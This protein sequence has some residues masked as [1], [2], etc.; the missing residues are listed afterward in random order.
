MPYRKRTYRYSSRNKKDS[1][2]IKKDMKKTNLIIVLT[3]LFTMLSYAQNHTST[4]NQSEELGRV[5]WYRDYDKAIAVAKRENKAVVLLFQ[6][7]PGCATC[8]NY[9]H[10]V[11]SHPLIVEALENSFI[12]LAIHNN[13][14]GKDREILKRFEEPSWNNPVVRIIDVNGNDLVNRIGNDYSAITLCQSLIRTLKLR[15]TPIPNYLQLL[16]LELSSVKH[17]DVSE[18]Y[19]A[20]HCFWTGEKELGKL[21]GVI[22]VESG[23]I[24]HNEVVKVKYNLDLINTTELNNYATLSGFNK[25]ENQN[26]SKSKKDVHYFLKNTIY[27]YMPLTELQK[28]KI[29]SALG[30]Q[31]TG[32]E[33]LSPKQLI[34]LNAYQETKSYTVLLDKEFKVAWTIKEMEKN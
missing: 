3:C 18:E 8:R 22:D 1:R 14:A 25:I 30:H 5:D 34:W 10:N 2:R 33:Y 27:K 26:Y 9:G 15:N 6:E 24:N 31:R 28:T 20:M 21:D 12:P 4:N 17:E 13:S 29:N 11:L 23:F 16:E 7:V 32:Q 19:F